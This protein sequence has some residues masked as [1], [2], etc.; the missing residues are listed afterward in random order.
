M[1][2]AII[3]QEALRLPDGQRALLADRLIES[4][5]GATP[6][7]RQAWLAEVDSR[8]EAFRR[9]KIQAVDGPEA[10]AELRARFRQ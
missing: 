5:S 3:E 9:G 6:A 7:L 4:L 8:M 2:M 10:M 1:D